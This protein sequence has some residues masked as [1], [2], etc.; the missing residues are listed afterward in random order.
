[1]QAAIASAAQSER[2]QWMLFDATN[3]RNATMLYPK[4]EWD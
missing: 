3:R 1:M 2:S 4:L